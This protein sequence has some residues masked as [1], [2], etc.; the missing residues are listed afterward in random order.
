MLA[1]R[2]RSMIEKSV[3]QYSIVEIA[4]EENIVRF[5]N[6]R[7][8][9][10]AG[11]IGRF[12]QVLATK[13]RKKAFKLIT[14]IAHLEE[15]AED[16]L[17]TL[18]RVEEGDVPEIYP[19]TSYRSLEISD[20]G[21]DLEGSIEKASYSI[22]EAYEAGADR[23]AGILKLYRTNYH[24]I[25]STGNEK[26][27]ERTDYIYYIRAFKGNG[28]GF[29]NSVST[30]ISRFDPSQVA[31]QA[32]SDAKSSESPRDMPEGKYTV[33]LAPPISAAIFELISSMCSAYSID[34]GFSFM[35]DRLGQSVAPEFLSITDHGQIEDGVNSRSFDDEGAPTTTNTL[36]EKGVFRGVIHNSITAKRWGSKTT[37]NAGV[38]EP[39]PWNVVVSGGDSG[40]D[41]MIKEV[42]EGVL[43]TNNWYT[44]FN[45]YRTGEFSTIVRDAAFYIKNGEIAYPVANIRLSDSLPRLLSS[46]RLMSRDT[47]WVKWWGE[48]VTPVKSPYVLVD[49]STLTVP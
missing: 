2:I 37:G 13:G 41:E 35:K 46:I 10:A 47:R 4:G 24:L 27:E 16:L 45:N 32:A 18:D 15:E 28:S 43:I 42:K 21:L 40:L 38:I 20:K 11:G 25:T 48:V 49:G 44:R 34:S 3:D 17:R 1:E 33:I 39:S 9:I 31:R 6:G 22:D 26:D 30:S 36:I 8:S 19:R 12:V 5:Y 14:N 23:V 29:G 7:F